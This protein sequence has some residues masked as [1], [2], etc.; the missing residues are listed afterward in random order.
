M[1]II[2]GNRKKMNLTPGVAAVVILAALMTI[3]GFLYAG[4]PHTAYGKVQNS[5]GGAPSSCTFTAYITSRPGETLIQSSAGCGYDAASGSWWVQCGNFSTSW[6]AGDVLRINFNDGAGG[7]GSDNVTLTSNSSDDAGTTTLS[8]STVQ[9]T[10]ATNPSGLSVKVD[11]GTYTAPHSFTWVPGHTHSLEVASPQDGGTGKRY[12]YTSWS[13]GGDRSHSYLVPG[14]NQ[15]VTANLKT[16]YELEVNS[17]YG[18]PTGDG[19]YDAGSSASFGVTTPA[20]GGS[21]TRYVLTGWTGSG[22]GSYTGGS[23]SQTVTMNNAITETASWKTQFELEVNSSYGS[24]TGDGWYDAGSSA[25][26]GVTTPASG[27]SGTRHLF[28]GWTG[29]GSGSYTGGSASQ[30]VTMNNAIT[31]TASWN[32]Q[33]Y[34]ATAESPASGGDISPSAPGGWYNSGSVVSVNAAE[35]GTYQF[36]GFS[37]NLSGTTRP[38]N[39]TMNSAKSVTANFGRPVQITINA[40]P[41]GRHFIVDGADYNSPQTF[42]WIES[43]THNLE[44]VSP[45]SGGTGKR[46]VFTSWSDGGDRNHSYIVPGSDQTVTASFKTQY[47]LTVN[48][49][50]GSPTGAGWY[51]TGSTAY[52]GVTSPDVQS[53]RRYTLDDWSGDYTGSNSSS[54]LL[55][56]EAKTITAGWDAEY[57]LDISSEYGIE[58]GEGW[59][60]SGVTANFSVSTLDVRGNTRYKFRKFGGDYSSYQS[61]GSI[62]MNDARNIE[63]EWSTEYYLNIQASPADGGTVSPPPPGAWYSANESVTIQA[64]PASQQAYVFTGWAGD[65]S[66]LENPMIVTMDQAKNITA[67]FNLN[68]QIRVTTLPEGLHMVVDQVEYV[69]PQN[70]PWTMGSSHTISVPAIQKNGDKTECRFLS[71]SD[72]G[73]Q[74]HQITI[75]DGSVFTANCEIFHYLDISV[76]PQDAGTVTPPS[77]GGWMKEDS[78]VTLEAYPD[79]SAG[80]LFAGWDGDLAGQE[81]PRELL[82]DG[83]KN[84]T[85]MFTFQTHTLIV[86][87]DDQVMGSVHIDPLRESYIHGETV[88]LIALPSDGYQF[89]GWSG[90]AQGSDTLVVVMN[91]DKHIGVHFS[92][93]DR[94]APILKYYYPPDGADQ[95]PGNT[96]VQIKIVDPAGGNGVD[97]SSLT[98]SIDN[99]PVLAD[100]RFTGSGDLSIVQAPDG[101]IITFVPPMPFYEDSQV[102]V[103]VQCPD[104]ASPPNVMTVSYSFRIGPYHSSEIGSLVI[105]PEGGTFNFGDS[106]PTIF[107]PEG[108]LEEPVEFILSLC[109]EV[110]DNPDGD[111]NI[112]L[113]YHIWPEGFQFADT[114]IIGVPYTEDLLIQ[115]G[116]SDPLDLGVNYYSSVQGQWIGLDVFDCDDHRVYVKITELCYFTLI[117][118]V[119]RIELSGQEIPLSF[120]LRQNYPNP[121]N[122]STTIAYDI[123]R[124]V[125]VTLEVFNMYG[126]RVRT[127]IRQRQVPGT[128]RIT[129]AGDDELGNRVSSGMYLF[130]LKYENQQ[131]TVKAMFMK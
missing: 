120:R 40:V 8:A 109:D 43:T 18:S 110:P 5:G 21:G 127:L 96:R 130:M 78:L 42:T 92:A 32:T 72:G 25:S 118:H 97:I 48:S 47:Q 102:D 83:P 95:V 111:A 76:S 65:L 17:S 63:V 124:P 67:N 104:K 57:Y 49:A 58:Q 114:V 37:G 62:V 7:T 70:F 10:I 99:S 68:G 61:S 74:T 16:Q 85:A 6:S 122:P 9:V 66:G 94:L 36:L 77:P 28:T 125:D 112:G 128:Y 91:Q 89:A 123:P 108:A 30:T 27:G 22:S 84:I 45:Q 3:P 81:C 107:V 60:D 119:T 64:D 2:V 14:S 1:L 75:G 79:T 105:G 73:N 31:E 59:Y 113:K 52:F 33:Y 44:V 50:H 71:W 103:F 90:D 46:Y 117:S 34:L 26:F 121:F 82:I 13:D 131:Q 87:N 93:D 12:V 129:W 86:E 98:L 54:S 126:Q 41:A 53:G 115:A 20:S 38:Q 24:P 4:T 116:I 88:T 29:S 69:S 101:Y 80:Y 23:T 15:T 11:G 106:G 51:D 56:N 19:W 55:M 100:G 35:S 39:I